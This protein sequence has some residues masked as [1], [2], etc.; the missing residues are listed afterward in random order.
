MNPYKNLPEDL[1]D[2]AIDR[3]LGP[4]L[5]E[6]LEDGVKFYRE[7]LSPLDPRETTYSLH[8][9]EQIHEILGVEYQ[10]LFAIGTYKPFQV[11]IRSL[12]IKPW[13]QLELF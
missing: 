5:Y 12:R 4:Y 3:V 7:V 10:S 1:L 11:N 6:E 13:T 8:I 9:H 2:G